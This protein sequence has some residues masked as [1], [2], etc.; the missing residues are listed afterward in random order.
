MLLN[1]L[2]TYL[3]S[4][5]A[6]GLP[7]LAACDEKDV[8]LTDGMVLAILVL[9]PIILIALLIYSIIKAIQGLLAFIILLSKGEIF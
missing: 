8:P 3:V 7:L 2:I 6:I 1:I 4:G 9:Y 5:V